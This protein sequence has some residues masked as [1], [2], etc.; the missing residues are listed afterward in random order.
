MR[1][2]NAGFEGE[3]FLGFAD[4][5]HEAEAAANATVLAALSDHTLLRVHGAD[6]QS[7]LNSQLSNDIRLVD[8][9]HSQ[10]AAWCNAKGRI[11]T[12]VRIFKRGNDYY[13]LLPADLRETVRERLQRFVLRAKVIIEDDDNLVILGVSGPQA[14]SLLHAALSHV[15][16][17]TDDCLTNNGVTLLRL[18]SAH[19]RCILVAPVAAVLTLWER[20]APPAVPTGP[21]AW[22]WLDIAA[23][24]PRIDVATSERFVPQ[25]VNLELLSGV[26]FKKG[27]YP[28]Q[29]IVARMH[30][31]G[32][33][34]QRMYRAHAESA[35]APDTPVFAPDPPG[36]PTGAV[37]AAA[38]A[39]AGGCDLLAVLHTSSAAAG[40][41]HL[42][43]ATGPALQLLPLPYA[44]PTENESNEKSTA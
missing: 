16:V 31:L 32:R 38:V 13:L 27:C 17:A 40:V 21:Q 15:P 29:E 34:K 12:L 20:L 44:L 3:T 43:S 4:A 30:Y 7:F 25:M 24:V 2:R 8:A 9:A 22:T 28:G 42:G 39:P 26:D 1:G 18:P 33:L 10:L 23:G 14:D 35:V 37:I 5:R 41:L 19:P 11:V 6:A 36:Q